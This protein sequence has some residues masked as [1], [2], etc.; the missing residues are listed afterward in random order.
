L[1]GINLILYFKTVLIFL[2]RKGSGQRS[3]VIYAGI[4]TVMFIF[5][6]LGI[7]R[8]DIRSKNVIAASKLSGRATRVRRG[9]YISRLHGFGTVSSILL[10]MMTDG[11][12]L[13]CCRII[14]NS[15]CV[16]ILPS[17]LWLGNIV[18]GFLVI[19]T[20]CT[21]ETFFFSGLA[22]KLGLAYYTVSVF[23]K[24]TLTCMI[25]Y[26]LLRHAKVV[27]E[28][29]GKEHASLYYRI[30]MLLVESVLP[31]TLSGIAFL[32]SYG[33]RSQLAIVFSCVYTL[34]M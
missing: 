30:V 8:G 4:S 20:S 21:P 27:R 17:I 19:W 12:V 10:Q 2:S 25:C 29:L 32:V 7:H 18:L 9:T 6:D 33:I 16:V 14:W 31:Y 1:P 15:H 22:A 5:H 34:M 24:A 26:R 28:F 23:L 3:D 11:L 13:H